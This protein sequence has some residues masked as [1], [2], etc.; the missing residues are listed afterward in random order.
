MS[1]QSQ[2]HYD[3]LGLERAASLEEIKQAY[4]EAQMRWHPDRNPN[5]VAAADRFR[6]AALA[7]EVLG[8][9]SKRKMY[10]LGID[11][12]GHFNPENFDL[13][14]LN[15]D[16]LMRG[17]A[18][19]FGAWFDAEAPGARERINDTI[20]HRAKKA[21]K[22]QQSTKAPSAPS[23]RKGPCSMCG[24]KGKVTLTQGNFAISRPCKACS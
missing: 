23:P 6:E 16:V 10:D 3:I 24:G 9:S 20:I 14:D 21:K 18:S 4:R 2:N 22:K 15:E 12:V 11:A 1:V 19:M 7:Y 8:D 5:D 13:G 17:F